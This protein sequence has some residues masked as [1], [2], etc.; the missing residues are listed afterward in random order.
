MKELRE[1]LGD[2]AD[3]DITALGIVA[4]VIQH[5][6]ARAALI[7]TVGFRAEPGRGDGL[8]LG[9]HG[10]AHTSLECGERQSSA[11]EIQNHRVH[12]SSIAELWRCP[13]AERG[14]AELTGRGDGTGVSAGLITDS[15]CDGKA[16][17]LCAAE[18]LRVVIQA[19]QIKLVV[20]DGPSEGFHRFRCGFPLF[21][22]QSEQ[23]HGAEGIG[24]TDCLI[25]PALELGECVSSWNVAH[26]ERESFCRVAVS[27]TAAASPQI[28]L[29]LAGDRVETEIGVSTKFWFLSDLSHL[30]AEI[31]GCPLARQACG[32]LGRE[33]L[34]AQASAWKFTP[35]RADQFETSFKQT[36][37]D[38]RT[39]DL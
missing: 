31:D 19:H 20:V 25:L 10:K 9:Q 35:H 1:Q 6:Q 4:W 15:G 36:T 7:S 3:R 21:S 16:Q 23:G 34:C 27:G 22:G 11:P 37:E 32:L 29:Y 5:Q 18:R 14:Q 39:A 30:P 38:L 33:L 2:R 8:S 13:I 24:G 17:R 26:R 12:Q 28:N